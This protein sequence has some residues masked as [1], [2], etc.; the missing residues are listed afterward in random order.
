MT[1]IRA[2]AIILYITE[3]KVIGQ[4]SVLH[5]LLSFTV[6]NVVMASKLLKSQ[7]SSHII[8]AYYLQLHDRL[9]VWKDS[10]F[11]YHRRTFPP[12]KKLAEISILEI[13]HWL[14]VHFH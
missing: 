9:I 4:H 10:E 12:T 13:L 1:M 7:L 5:K 11:S 6:K 8:D 2:I 3:A 14:D